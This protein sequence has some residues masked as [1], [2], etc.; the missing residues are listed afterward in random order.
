LIMKSAA[1]VIRMEGPYRAFYYG[2]TTG[3]TGL[4]GRQ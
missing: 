2:P 1:K 3:R 4:V